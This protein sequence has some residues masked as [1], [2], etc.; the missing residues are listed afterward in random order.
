MLNA[1][2][3]TILKLNKD[4]ELLDLKETIKFIFAF[5]VISF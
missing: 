5:L 3:A 4:L 1:T 2:N